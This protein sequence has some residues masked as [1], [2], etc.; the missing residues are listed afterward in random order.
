MLRKLLKFF[1]GRLFISFVLISLQIWIL[2]TIFSF[3]QNSTLWIQFLSALSILMTLVVVTRD[4][5]P[6]YKIGW[7]L[8]FMS[9]P[10]YG[11]LFYLFFGN[12]KLNASL[13]ARLEKLNIFYQKGVEGGTYSELLP[14]KALS[15][16]S[17]TLARQA[18]Y[19]ANITGFPVWGNTEV[20]YFSSGEAWVLDV[21]S[22]MRKAKVFHFHGV[23]HHQRGGSLGLFPLGPA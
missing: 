15:S 16:Y 3:A 4:L 21:L 19:I 18:Q 23:F 20:E 8:I 9:I 13:R 17:P 1:T 14:M 11:G 5:N 2:V 7:M 12:R 10:V 22:E 6:A